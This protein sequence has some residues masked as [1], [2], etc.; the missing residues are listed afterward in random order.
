[1]Y[2]ELR[3]ESLAGSPSA[4]TASPSAACRSA[5]PRTRCDASSPTPRPGCPSTSRATSWVSAPRR[6]RRR[7]ARGID[8]F[9]CVMPTRN[10]RNGWLFTRFGDHQDQER[11]PPRPTPARSTKCDC[12]TCRNF[13]R[14][15]LHHLHRSGEILGDAQHHSQPAL[16]PDPS[17]PKSARRSKRTN[18]PPSWRASAAHER[19]RFRLSG[20]EHGRW[21]QLI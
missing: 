7:R 5:S 1:M 16:L 4:F 10:A 13:S 2:E 9:D 8:M 20:G 19:R 14:A 18:S 11:R 15:Y 12:Y 17:R 6:H 21:A 3:D